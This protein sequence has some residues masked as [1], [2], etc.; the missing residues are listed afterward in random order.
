VNFFENNQNNYGHSGRS[1]FFEFAHLRPAHG[2]LSDGS[3]ER[4]LVAARTGMRKMSSLVC[5]VWR[6]AAKNIALTWVQVGVCGL[7][8]GI[9]E[10]KD[11]KV[12]AY[13]SL[14]Q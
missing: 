2:L 6:T 5:S 7:L 8:E 11:L 4:T 9:G 14:A 3:I 10:T 1:R 12:L 13:S